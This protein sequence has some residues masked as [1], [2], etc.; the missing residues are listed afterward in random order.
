MH[1]P[2]LEKLRAD[3]CWRTGYIFINAAF[4]AL[5]MGNEEWAENCL[6]EGLNLCQ[7]YHDPKTIAGIYMGLGALSIA[8]ENWDRA[9]NYLEIAVDAYQ[10]IGWSKKTLNLC[11]SRYYRFQHDYDN[12]KKIL[13]TVPDYSDRDI[14]PM[15]TALSVEN[16][17][18]EMA[19]GNFAK[20]KEIIKRTLNLTRAAGWK[21][22]SSSACW[23]MRNSTPW[24]TGKKK[25]CTGSIR[26]SR[27]QKPR[28]MT[29]F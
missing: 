18:Y 15:S 10:K 13:K 6:N 16:G 9:R 29:D 27:S 24:N 19:Q 26:P 28:V 7:I 14:V 20:A 22:K 5:E 2:L 8:Q 11:F 17:L 1:K 3:Y 12:M 25:P 4:N 23:P 21:K